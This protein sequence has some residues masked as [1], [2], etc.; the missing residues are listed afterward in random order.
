MFVSGI[1]QKASY[2]FIQSHQ[3][4]PGSSGGL[5]YNH[6][7]CSYQPFD[8]NRIGVVPEPHEIVRKFSR[9]VLIQLESHF[10]RIGT[11]RSSCASSA[12]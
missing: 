10:V 1:P 6:I 12:A 8:M 5:Y 2:T 11:R 3:N 4:P 9:K 7:V